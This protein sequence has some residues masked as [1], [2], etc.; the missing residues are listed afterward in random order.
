[1]ATAVVRDAA[2]FVVV[3][4]VLVIVFAPGDVVLLVD[5]ID[6][7]ASDPVAFSDTAACMTVVVAITGAVVAEPAVGVKLLSN[8]RVVTGNVVEL[9]IV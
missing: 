1:M 3:H 6:A 5:V 8:G 2:S 4:V 9:G 7:E